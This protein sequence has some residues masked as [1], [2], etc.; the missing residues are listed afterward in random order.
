MRVY[1]ENELASGRIT[2]DLKPTEMDALREIER[3][4]SSGKIKEGYIA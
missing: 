2:E 1:L 4:H 3:D